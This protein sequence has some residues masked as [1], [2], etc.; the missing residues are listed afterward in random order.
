M[1]SALE[2]LTFALN[3]LGW[4]A[5]PS[6]FWDVTNGKMLKKI[7]PLDIIGAPTQTPPRTPKPGYTT[8]FPSVQVL[9]QTQEQLISKVCELH[10]VSKHRETIFAGSQG[11]SDPPAGFYESLGISDKSSNQKDLTLRALSWPAAKIILKYDPKTPSLQRVSQPVG[12]RDFLEDL[13]PSFAVLINGSG[14]SA[15]TDAQ[16]NIPLKV[17]QFRT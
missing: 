5:F 12:Q 8:V 17:G 1:D 14:V 7:S 13:V 9:W 11:R 10:D 15:L 2:C 16:T 3:A 6:E 4:A